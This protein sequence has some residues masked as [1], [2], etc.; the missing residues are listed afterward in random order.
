[1][2]KNLIKE[3]HDVFESEISHNQNLH[4]T[5]L[6]KMFQNKDIVFNENKY[7]ALNLLNDDNYYTNLALLLSDECP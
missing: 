5:Y 4:F 1:M 2:I 6:K 3:N 7:K